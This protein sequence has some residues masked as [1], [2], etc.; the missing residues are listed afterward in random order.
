MKKLTKQ[1][2]VS[3]YE[4]GSVRVAERKFPKRDTRGRFKSDYTLSIRQ[5]RMTCAYAELCP[6]RASSSIEEM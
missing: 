4:D 2:V 5:K 1:Y 3:I 6:F